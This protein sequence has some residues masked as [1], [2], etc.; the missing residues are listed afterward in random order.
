MLLQV[1]KLRLREIVTYPRLAN[2]LVTNT[3]LKPRPPDFST[4]F[5]LV[6]TDFSREII[7]L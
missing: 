5:W 3:K 1:K 7:P 2:D 6:Y 4:G